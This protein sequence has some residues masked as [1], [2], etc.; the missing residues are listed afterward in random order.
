MR[1]PDVRVRRLARHRPLRLER[2]RERPSSHS[3][4]RDEPL[5]SRCVVSLGTVNFD[6]SASACSHSSCEDCR[7][8][9]HSL[10]P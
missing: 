8:C 6:S 7:C 5:M 9:V 1:L 2:L 3:W 10:T 4:P